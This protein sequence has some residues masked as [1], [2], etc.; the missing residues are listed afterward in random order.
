MATTT[1]T[2]LRPANR[3][4]QHVPINP[5]NLLNGPAPCGRGDAC[6][7]DAQV[8]LEGGVA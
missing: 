2:T 3:V 4:I 1:V 5:L 7:V 8:V 6:A